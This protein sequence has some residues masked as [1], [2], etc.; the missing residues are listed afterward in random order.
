MFA[1]W[2]IEKNTF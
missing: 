1:E 2:K